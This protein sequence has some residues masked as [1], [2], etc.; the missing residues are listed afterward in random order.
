[1]G[2]NKTN[3][4]LKFSDE[5]FSTDTPLQREMVAYEED[6]RG[7][8]PNLTPMRVN[9]KNIN[10]VWN[11]ELFQQFLE[12]S[13]RGGY[14][15]GTMGEDDEEELREIFFNRLKRILSTINQHRPR[16][17][18]TVQDAQQRAVR[19]HKE[20]LAISRRNTRRKEVIST[21]PSAWE[22][23]NVLTI[24]SEYAIGYY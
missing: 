13:E 5:L 15:D 16:S 21:T 19:R 11:E 2:I 17:N 9:W 24:A 6:G 8:G 10:G 1:M 12:F 18:E 4:V 14:A 3:D 7:P 22:R 20:T 23:A